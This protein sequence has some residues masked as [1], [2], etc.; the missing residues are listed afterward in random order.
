VQ[1]I[2]LLQGAW[3]ELA[4]HTENLEAQLWE[5]QREAEQQPQKLQE[6]MERVVLEGNNARETLH[7]RTAECT[8]IFWEV[9]DWMGIISWCNQTLED[10]CM[11]I[12][13]LNEE[14]SI[15]MDPLEQQ[16][17]LTRSNKQTMS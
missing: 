13:S 8:R 15:T 6:K 10:L 4:I 7:K 14:V 2:E 17:N 1:Q 16:E 3:S 5:S 12:Q 9:S 11:K